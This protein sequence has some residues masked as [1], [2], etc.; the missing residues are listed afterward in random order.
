M[1]IVRFLILQPTPFCN[2][3]CK[4]CYLPDRSSKAAMSLETIN[5]IFS[6]LFSSGWVGPEL[7]VAWHVGE[8][9]A[10]PV[11]YYRDAFAAIDRL[12]PSATTIQYTFQTN[13]M[14]I[15][16]EWCGFFKAHHVQ[17]GVSVDGP[18]DVHDANRI[19]RSGAPTFAQTIA[20]IRCLQR[21][22]V[23]FGIIT[24]LSGAALGRAREFYDFYGREGI[25]GICFNAEEIEG[26]NKS[27]SLTDREAEYDGFLRTFWNMNVA[28]NDLFYIREFNEILEKI[29]TPQ[30]SGNSL[31]EPFMHLNVDWQGNYSTFSPEFL[32]HKNEYYGDFII[33][34][35]YKNRLVECLESA[36]F[37]RM[38]NDIAEGVTLCR[39]SCEYFPICGGG[40]PVNKLYENGTV[41]SAETMFCRLNVK[42][43]A[44]IAMEII[45]NSAD[46]LGTK[47]P[48]A[49]QPDMA[50]L[51]RRRP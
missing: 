33:G 35:F 19:T 31:V 2:I 13:G 28:S 42:L 40:S 45:E 18:R 8:P 22:D 20:G 34:N 23:D 3:S 12:T 17:V 9:L 6:D 25:R 10:L 26:S 41:A 14:L 1:P 27:T 30:E 4:Y 21:N 37:K 15:D 50:G 46:A 48:G 29:M 51:S 5:R 32:G 16:D 38:R 36:S 24:V 11:A 7:M 39:N 49:A 47:L 43:P 44:D